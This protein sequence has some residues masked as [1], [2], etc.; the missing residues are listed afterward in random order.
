MSRDF[1]LHPDLAGSFAINGTVWL[2]PW[3]VGSGTGGSFAKA[4]FT[5]ALYDV[6]SSGQVVAGTSA[7]TGSLNIAFGTT[8]AQSEDVNG[9]PGNAPLKFSVGSYTFL[10]GHSILVHVEI[11]PQGSGT[12]LSLYFDNQ[13]TPSFVSL[14]SNSIV[15]VVSAWTTNSTGFPVAVFAQTSVNLQVDMVANVT[16]PLGGYDINA[17]AVGTTY[18]RVT[19]NLTS[20]TTAKLIVQQRMSLLSGG[21]VSFQNH[22]GL[23]YTFTSAF[24]GQYNYTVTAIDN[25]G[26]VAI[27]NGYFQVGQVYRLQ[28]EAVDA[29]DRPL[30][31]ATIFGKIQGFTV[32]AQ[33]T[34]SSGWIDRLV[35]AGSYTLGVIWRGTVVNTT[36]GYL[37]AQNST[38]VLHSAVY[39]PKFQALDDVNSGLPQAE[40][41]IQSPNGTSA[42]YPLFT[43]SN[44]FVNLT[45]SQGGIYHLIVLWKGV[46]V[47]NNTVNVTSDGPFS[48]RTQVYQIKII[49]QGQDG[50]KLSG[51]L[52]AIH[53]PTSAEIVYSFGLTDS[54]GTIIFRLP[55]GN[56]TVLGY[57]S[58]TYLLTAVN[59][60]PVFQGI[61]V[62]S[63]RTE[64]LTFQGVPP[65]ITSTLAF[66]LGGLFLILLVLAAGG[67]YFVGKRGRGKPISKAS[68][69]TLG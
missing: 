41:F 32:F 36:S 42:T 29:K 63:S 67:G 50:S 21:R 6:S 25:S 39:D 9:V 37:I 51:A 44:G 48:F 16:D 62:T 40:V 27:G 61:T 23:N 5:V 53:S 11:L 52:I 35:V 33:D 69:K 57:Y 18:A 49:A 56:Y 65:P 20:P 4:S 47:F 15:T 3:V 59:S 1:Y 60:P 28:A 7:S 13:V 12:V 64:T 66:Q 55:V 68:T 24:P 26:N 8:A 38:I 58:T 46:V 54:T 31:S 10:P 17:S 14:Y 19:L 2:H 43:T 34:N 30:A 45:E 22:F